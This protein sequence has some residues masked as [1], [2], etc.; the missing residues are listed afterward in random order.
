MPA[1]RTGR[2][3]ASVLSSG[4]T[5]LGSHAALD[6]VTSGRCRSEAP[7]DP[8]VLILERTFL[9]QQIRHPR[10]VG[11]ATRPSP[12]DMRINLEVFSMFPSV[13][14]AGRPFAV[15]VTHAPRKT[16]FE[17]LVRFY[18]TGFAPAGSH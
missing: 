3:R 6:R 8:Y 7:T 11:V 17:P 10:R 9:S 5:K 2:T 12:V 4:A 13:E 16:R 14:S 18:W 15:R 1:K